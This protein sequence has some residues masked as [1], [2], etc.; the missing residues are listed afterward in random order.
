MINTIKATSAALY[1][2]LAVFVSATAFASDIEVKLRAIPCDYT[3]KDLLLITETTNHYTL[4]TPPFQLGESRTNLAQKIASFDKCETV[5]AATIEDVLPIAITGLQNRSNW[6][7]RAPLFWYRIKCKVND[8]V[9]GDFPHTTMEFVATGGGD[10]IFWQF[11]RGYAFYWGFEKYEDG[12]MI[13]EYYRTSPL[14]PYK[15]ED[16][17]WYHEMKRKNPDFDWSQPD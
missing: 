17:I 16:H 11:V 1:T 7:V 4:P 9:K 2:L 14:P 5:V 3:V 13:K 8:V 10:R 6:G 15:M 12:W